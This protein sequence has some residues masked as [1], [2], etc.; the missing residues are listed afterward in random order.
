[1]KALRSI[2]YGYAVVKGKYVVV[3]DEAEIV[4]EIFNRYSDGEILKSISDNLTE[5]AVRY[6]QEKTTWTKNL[7]SR[8]VDNVIYLGNETYP[9]IITD[10]LFQKAKSQKKEKGAPKT[11]LPELTGYVKKLLSCEACGSGF[12]RINKWKSR[13]KW[14]C[15]GGCKCGTYLDDRFLFES[16]LTVL[17]DV[18]ENPELLDLAQTDCATASSMEIT[19]QTNDI[20]RAMDQESDF[21]V[22]TEMI[23]NCA[24]TKYDNIKE[25]NNSAVTEA[26]KDY[27]IQAGFQQELRLEMLKATVRNITVSSDGTVQL[28]FANG[29]EYSTA[30]KGANE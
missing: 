19:K 10:A 16:I 24:E 5:R 11:E 1:M 13:E 20:Y 30:M 25:E 2:F 27:F 3:P 15:S 12:R 22:I 28:C 17:N 21:K 7:V 4:K 23:F 14:L 6:Y 18:I 8:I 26:L 9:R 29:S